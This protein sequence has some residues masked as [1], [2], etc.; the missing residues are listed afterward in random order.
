VFNN[1]N[2]GVGYVGSPPTR[3]LDVN[4]TT[5]LRCFPAP[6]GFYFENYVYTELGTQYNEAI[7]R[8]QWGN[9]AWLGKPNE[10]FWHVHSK[11]F[12]SDATL[13]GSDST[14]KQNIRAL[15]NAVDLVNQLHPVMY[16]LRDE[17]DT[18]LS[19]EKNALISELGK[20]NIGFLAQEIE[21]VLPQLVHH[22]E[23]ENYMAV[24]YT[25]LIPLL[26]KAIQEQQSRIEDLE[27][28][29]IQMQDQLETL[30]NGNQ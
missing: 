21:Q 7:I 28:Q 24:N 29:L 9:G 16:D 6:F 15:E 12:Y 2:V 20:D 25:A 26:T 23:S 30:T 3:T 22:Q 14:R 1:N 10:Q 13:I 5:Y 17:P 4:G 19:E 11:Y 18:N 8:P 27:T